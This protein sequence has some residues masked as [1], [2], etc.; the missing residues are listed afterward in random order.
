M[1][2]ASILIALVA[3]SISI[4]A[5]TTIAE[6]R[7][8]PIGTVV[9]V[10]GIATNGSELGN[11]R[12]FQDQTG[13]IAA[14]SS[15]LSTIQRGD[16]ILVT[17]TLKSYNNLLEIDPV[18]SFN[19]LSSNNAVP[20]PQIITP[21]E[22]NESLEA[23]LISIEDAV[24]EGSSGNF[25]GNTNYTIS[26]GGETTVFRVGNGNPLVGTLIPSNP[27]TLIAIVS[28]Y[29]PS[30]PT[31]GYQLLPRDASDIIPQAGIAIISP[32]KATAIETNS[33]SIS[34]QTDSIGST[35][36]MYGLTP[37][38][39][40]GHL[41]FNS[42]GT[43]HQIT[44]NTEPGTLIYVDAFSVD[45][46]DTASTGTKVF[47]SKSLSSGD[48]KVYF[49]QP[50]DTTVSTGT[51]A[52]SLNHSFADTIIAY[53][54]RAQQT[55]DMMMYDNDCR[56]IID[57]L[58][59]AHDRG[60]QIRFISD[61]PG[62]TEP[63]DTV[64]N[65]LNPEIA[66]LAGN[67]EAIM[68]NKILI[69]DRENIDQCIVMTGSTNHTMANLNDD[70]NNLVIIQDQA[71]VKAY[72]IEFY[73]MWG[74]TTMSPDTN[75]AKFGSE[76][77]DNTPHQLNIGGK[78]FELYFSPSAH[79]TSKIN[80]ALLSASS[81]LEFGVMAFTENV[82]G[83]T[84][85]T[86]HESGVQVHGIIDYVEFTGSEFQ[87]LLA[88][89]VQVL[90][91]QN[92]DGSQWPLGATF[93][94][95]Y[96]I[97]DRNSL[98]SDPLVI[99][100]SHNWTATADSKNDE[101]TLIIHDATIANL[102][103]QEFN[104]SF[105][106]LLTPKPQNDTIST[107]SNIEIGIDYASNDFIHYQVESAITSIIEEPSHG[108]ANIVNNQIIYTSF[109]DF[110]GID[111]LKYSVCNT[112]LPSLC[113]E[114]WIKINIIPN[115][116]IITN[117]D[118]IAIE[119][120]LVKEPIKFD[121]LANDI[122][123]E[124]YEYTF[125]IIGQANYGIVSYNLNDTLFSYNP[126]DMPSDHYFDTV[127]YKVYLTDFPT[128][129]DTALVQI[130]IDVIGSIESQNSN[131]KIILYPNPT[132][133]FISIKSIEPGVVHIEIFSLTGE[134]VA[135]YQT[136]VNNGEIAIDCSDLTTGI[137]IMKAIINDSIKTTKLIKQ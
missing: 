132:S 32:L 26:S 92:P 19:I 72:M 91:Y 15:T 30:N 33:I 137:Y 68:H 38:L 108:I 63:T 122:I 45:D 14:Y 124:G 135:F 101:N 93:H 27:F 50:I 106:N 78:Y 67:S 81:V 87:M 46:N 98:D 115:A 134:K 24:I 1:K 80:D 76:K 127:Y 43:N 120:L 53:I 77:S 136:S 118:S 8:L 3:F 51:H 11:I 9:T 12:Y 105:N 86:V 5:Q 4:K 47:V 90:D 121:L 17:G 55:I 60:V 42:Q 112:N 54:G 116:E 28:Q 39:E 23:Q 128:I 129:A 69:F 123:P 61:I 83:T 97:V 74:T 79:T 52:I 113:G 70:Y 25:A 10:K 21:S 58:N 48:I 133:D 20:A 62:D 16:S 2:K 6:A 100:G 119:L 37:E 36:I 59:A 99:N 110:V 73:E 82:L 94:S 107:Q 85:K 71:L 65:H 111:S 103:Y 22:V 89:G 75:N 131:E 49:N 126:I 57:A 64:L 18:S 31:S 35:E 114:A 104:Q 117:N 34:W 109:A 66:F 125:E 13:G 95:K 96:A 40:L 56:A 7:A 84:I 41:D 44:I 88:S 102:F 29:S 130:K